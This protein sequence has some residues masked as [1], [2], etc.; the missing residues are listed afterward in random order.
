MT[1][2]D[3]P[4]YTFVAHGIHNNTSMIRCILHGSRDDD[5]IQDTYTKMYKDT[6]TWMDTAAAAAAAGITQAD[7]G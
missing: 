7:G 1:Y 5:R 3:D 2:P 4:L 6:Y